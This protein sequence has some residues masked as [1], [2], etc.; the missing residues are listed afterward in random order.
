MSSN[1]Y[2]TGRRSEDW[3]ANYLQGL[4]WIILARNFRGRHGEID[5]VARHGSVIVFVEIKGSL[6]QPREESVLPRQIAR[7]RGAAQEFLKLHHLSQ[8]SEMR[9]DVLLVWG[10]PIQVQ[11][12][13]DAF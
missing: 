3:A 13:Q 4:G 2:E 9:F 1:S 8:E 6:R 11:H 12:L 7:V 10:S 5:L